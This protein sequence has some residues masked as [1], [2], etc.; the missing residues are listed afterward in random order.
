MT[1]LV[2]VSNRVIRPRSGKASGGLAVGV[3]A[4]LQGHGGVWFGWSGRTTPQEPDDAK[5]VKAGNVSFATIDLNEEDFD[6]YYNG[7]SNNCLWPLFHYLLGFFH[8]DR[9]Q[10]N[11]YCRVNELFARKLAPLLEPGDIIW[12]HDFHLIPL[13]TE[14]R[15]LGVEQPIGFFLHVPFPSFDV[16]RALPPYLHILRSLAAYDVV[17]FQTQRDLF[18]FE[19]SVEQSELAGDVRG[20]GWIEACGRRFR[21]GA[22]PIGI[23]VEAC[24]SLAMENLDHPQVQ[25]LVNSLERRALMIGVDRLDYSKG[26]ELRFRAYERLLSDYPNNLGRVIFMQIAPPTRTGVRTYQEIREELERAA[27]SINGRFAEIDWVP[28]RYLNRAYSRDVLMALLRLARVGLVTPIRD[29]MNLVAK[30]YIAAQN[31]KNPGVLVLSTLAGAAR[32]LV[33]AVLVNPYDPEGLAEG[34]QRALSMPLGERC[35]R[36]RSMLAALRGNDI[37]AWCRRFVEALRST[38]E[39][40][41]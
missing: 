21:A 34:M 11:A 39:R 8:F 26:L 30:E 36:H 35:E 32:E 37:H 7:F 16:L 15:R 13:A 19:E 17:G 3:M 14:L 24:E 25:R 12:V 40:P 28:I 9:Q 20:E 23:D 38:V 33:D 27:G 2:A 5:V 31:P 18:S 6:G 41:R 29:G 22:F 4:A 1:R 10:Y